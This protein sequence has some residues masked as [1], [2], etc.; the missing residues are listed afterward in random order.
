V[1]HVLVPIR[2]TGAT[3]LI[4]DAALLF[5]PHKP[6][7]VSNSASRTSC[8]SWMAITS[9][10]KALFACSSMPQRRGSHGN[11]CSYRCLSCTG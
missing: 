9:R 2:Q 8:P 11:K 4:F 10:S 1:L 7:A 3:T 6:V 5:A